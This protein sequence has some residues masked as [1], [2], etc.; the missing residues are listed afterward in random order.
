MGPNRLCVSKLMENDGN[1]DNKHQTNVRHALVQC[2][3]C[4]N[5]SKTAEP[6]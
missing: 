3:H 2:K 4:N 1:Y 5:L 6:R